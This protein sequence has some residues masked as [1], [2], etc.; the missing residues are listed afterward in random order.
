M[1]CAF[2]KGVFF[3]LLILTGALYRS[4]PPNFFLFL[5]ADE[6]T[7]VPKAVVVVT[8]RGLI[9]VLEQRTQKH[10]Q[11][12][13]FSISLLRESS[14]PALIYYG[15]DLCVAVS[16]D[17][18]W[19]A[20]DSYSFFLYNS[21]LTLMGTADT[22]GNGVERYRRK[23]T[24]KFHSSAVWLAGDYFLLMRNG[25]GEVIRLDFA[26]DRGLDVRMQ[27]PRACQMLS[28][29]S[30]LSGRLCERRNMWMRFCGRPGLRQLKR[31][32]VDKAKEMELNMFRKVMGADEVE[33]N[34]NLLL[35]SRDHRLMR[36]T[37]WML[38]NVVGVP[39]ELKAVS[40]DE[41]FNPTKGDA[42]EK[43][44]ETFS[45][46][47]DDCGFF[48]LP[49]K[50]QPAVY[51]FCRV[52]ALNGSGGKNLMREILRHWPGGG[53]SAMFMG[54]RQDIDEL[55]GQNPSLRQYFPAENCLCEEP[56]T[57]EEL[58]VWF[59]FKVE[60]EGIAMTPE[61]KDKACRLLAEAFRR[62]TVC[63]WTADDVH[64]FVE[65]V[66]KPAYLRNTVRRIEAGLQEP[67]EFFLL[68]DDLCDDMLLSPSSGFD[69]AMSELD[70]MVGLRNIK[71]D[72]ATLSNR[73]RF[74]AERRQL[75]LP[76]SDAAPHHAIF[77]GNP[78]TGKTT[79]ARLLGKVYQALGLLS[80]GEVVCVDRAKMVG[81]Y[82]GETEENMKMILQEAQGNVLFVD[83]AYTLYNKNDDKDFGRH[84]V[85]ALFEV[86]AQ[87]NPDM[88]IIF[89]GYEQEMEELMTMN[90]GLRGRFPHKFHFDDYKAEEL[91]Q[92]AEHM[93]QRDQYQ[94]TEEAAC[95]LQR[96]IGKTV[97]R[98]D[99]DFANARWIGQLVGN[100]IIPAMADRVS[101]TPHAME[102]PVYQRVEE[103]DVRVAFE[104]LGAKAGHAH[105]RRA[106]GFCA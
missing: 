74:Y 46:G 38:K 12:T 85:E 96:M 87:K 103:Q 82:I 98:Q 89:A 59:F 83:E 79:V 45:E 22:N 23:L 97:A 7:F 40:C 44:R 58:I 91:M 93:L 11:M 73:M 25:S 1:D 60:K 78:G 4:V 100:G 24:V 69:Q 43:L 34:C 101:S 106:I 21:Q 53:S 81:R 30:M 31:W 51:S 67:M 64:R 61:A 33:L 80:K 102:P 92:I 26:L 75:G 42:Y 2:T 62:G 104:R 68:A 99:R 57:L 63:L 49:E 28:D 65:N 37:A 84:A 16:L 35:T 36:T 3:D 70:G 14:N 9:C 55:L 94:M 71:D 41:L 20:T 76:G 86:L 66:M 5:P 6:T 13:R 47:G 54:S 8:R 72:I 10:K 18:S 52:W 29:E 27:T 39:G 17:R 88:L 50:K 48:G 19:K 90:P 32:A 77:T 15:G 56:P 105:Q 95:L